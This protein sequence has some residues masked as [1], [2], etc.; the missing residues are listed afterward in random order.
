MSVM[1]KMADAEVF[2]NDVTDFGDGLVPRFF[3]IGQLRSL[4]CFSHTDTFF[5]RA[6]KIYTLC[7][8]EERS[9]VTIL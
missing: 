8:C 3:I 2:L 6:L 7:H 1:V 4:C 5:E 9:D